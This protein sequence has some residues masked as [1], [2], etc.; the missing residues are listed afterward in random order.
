[1]PLDNDAEAKANLLAKDDSDREANQTATGDNENLL[2]DGSQT[3]MAKGG[4][5]TSKSSTFGET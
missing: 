5:K 3:G 1:M 4:L 2:T